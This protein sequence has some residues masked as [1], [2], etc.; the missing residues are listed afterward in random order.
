MR[1][2][3]IE[4][5]PA[6]FAT[7]IEDIA[8][9][10]SCLYGPAAG[11]AYRRI[12]P[13]AVE[14]TMCSKDV[15]TLCA[16]VDGEAAGLV[17][18]TSKDNTG[19][20]PFVHVLP[21]YCGKGVEDSLICDAVRL[22]RAR[23]VER[24]TSECIPFCDIELRMPFEELG[25]RVFP[26]QIMG[27]NTELLSNLGKAVTRTAVCGALDMRGAAETVVGAYQDHPE[28]RLHADVQTPLSAEA[29]IR[30]TLRGAYGTS[31]PEYV[32]VVREHGRIAGVILG[33]EVA[34]GVGFILQV[35]VR[36]DAQSRGLGTVLIGDLATCFLKRGMKKT[37]L[38]VTVANRARSLYLRLG[39]EPLRDVDAFV[40]KLR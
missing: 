6:N 12:A 37:A 15:H 13:K 33:C 29:Y 21:A 22:L 10:L 40:W 25:F 27:A 26:R 7:Y 3:S 16:E 14:A 31:R 18:A 30:M 9:G 28:G 17:M 38:G 32:R 24:I 1:I 11:H 36:P 19:G 20:I 35:A 2:T 5:P 8:E 23:G 4:R 39:F 34:P